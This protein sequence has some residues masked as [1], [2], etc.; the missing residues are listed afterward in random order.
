MRG[1]NYGAFILQCVC[2]TLI[3]SLSLIKEN[4]SFE[5]CINIIG[6]NLVDFFCLI[7]VLAK[8]VRKA[9]LELDVLRGN[10]YIQR[11]NVSKGEDFK[12]I[13]GPIGRYETNYV[14]LG[15]HSMLFQMQLKEIFQQ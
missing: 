11:S 7:F 6:S 14:W 3:R 15:F 12:R 9:M 5:H 4:S 10:Q 1:L 8:K 2:N 13:W